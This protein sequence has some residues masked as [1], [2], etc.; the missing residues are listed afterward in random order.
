MMDTIIAIVHG[1]YGLLWN[2]L[3]TI[4]LPGGGT[5][6]LSLLVLIL[7]PT[8]IYF[9]IRTKFLQ[10]RLFPDMVRALLEKKGAQSHCLSTLQT[11]IVSTATRVG[12]GNLVGV[13]A[14]I[15]AG[16]AGAVFGC[17][18][19]RC[20]ALPPLS[21]KRPL[22]SFTK[23]KTPLRR[24][25]RRSRLLHPSLCGR[26]TRQKAALFHYGS[27]VCA[28]GSDLLVRYQSGHQQLRFLRLRDSFHIP[29]LYTTIVLVALAAVIVL[30]KNATVN[31]W[32]YWY[33]LWQAAISSSPLC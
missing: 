27:A 14:A 33:P 5:L 16:G 21:L 24:L 29:P 1:I 22:H 12:M 30:R 20:S 2:D 6:G 32:T 10:I 25:P 15:S 8:G 23:K 13:V 3:I 4:P 28:V 11:L 18:Y 19:L 26:E 31:Y 7:I 9:T 17:G